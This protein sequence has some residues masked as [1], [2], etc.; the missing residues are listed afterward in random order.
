MSAS[1]SGRPA[2]A[3]RR[4]HA[5][6][7]KSTPRYLPYCGDRGEA[8]LAPNPPILH[9]HLVRKCPEATGGI[10]AWHEGDLTFEEAMMEAVKRLFLAKQEL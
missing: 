6:P 9:R 8:I 4:L 3:I 5:S 10:D 7:P 2:E 1:P